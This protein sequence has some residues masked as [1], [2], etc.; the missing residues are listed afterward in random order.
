MIAGE[1]VITEI[2]L[3]KSSAIRFDW[4]FQYNT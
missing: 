1:L 2:K 3:A 4:I